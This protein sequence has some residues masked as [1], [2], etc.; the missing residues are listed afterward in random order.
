MGQ[1]TRGDVVLAPFALENR[2]VVK[3]RPAV[4]I[5]TGAQDE[6]WLCPVSSKT[7]LRC[8]VSRGLPGGFLPGRAGPVS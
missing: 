3:T 2:G 5:G 8:T 7:L 1:Y 4:V 6:V